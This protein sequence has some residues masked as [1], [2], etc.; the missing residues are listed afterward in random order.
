MN[1]IKVTKKQIKESYRHIISIGYCNL[2][3]LLNYMQPFAY[4]TRVE[5]WAC[6]YYNIEGVIISTGYAPIGISVDYELVNK[7]EREGRKL[8]CSNLTWKEKKE[9]AMELLNEFI[10]EVIQ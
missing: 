10:K 4:S 7:Y 3:S 2:Q 8:R 5:G 6:D 1:K 9:R